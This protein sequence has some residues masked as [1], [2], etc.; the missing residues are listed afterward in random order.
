M[1]NQKAENNGEKLYKDLQESIMK[2]ELELAYLSGKLDQAQDE[3]EKEA[4][5]RRYLELARELNQK[6]YRL[7]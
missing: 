6:K 7:E 3:E 1:D 5:N 2:L 4:L